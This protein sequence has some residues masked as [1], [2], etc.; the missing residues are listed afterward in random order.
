MALVVEDGTGLADATSFVSR[1]DYIA[2]AA[3]R[4]VTIADEE[5]ADV[6]LVKAMDYL[7]TKCYRGDALNGSQSLPFP[8]RVENFDG[9]LAFPDDEVPAGMKRGQMFAALAVHDGINLSPVS[10][11]GAAIKREKIGPIETEYETAMT[12]DAPS[13]P[14]VRSAIAPY[15]CGQGAR[16]RTVRV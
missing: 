8:R 9:T 7:L 14:A 13:L 3:A 5:A 12:Y 10:A 2:F 1:A 11:G 4:G 6:E 15:E 16:L